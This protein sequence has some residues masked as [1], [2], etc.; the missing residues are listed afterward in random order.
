MH[1]LLSIIIN[2][3]RK[4]HIVDIDDYDLIDEM[5]NRGY[6]VSGKGIDTSL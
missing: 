4:E 3:K 5:N 2:N 1:V 6:E